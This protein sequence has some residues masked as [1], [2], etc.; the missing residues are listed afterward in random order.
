MV[1]TGERWSVSARASVQGLLE[2]NNKKKW[3]MLAHQRAGA[4]VVMPGVGGRNHRRAPTSGL[5]RRVSLLRLHHRRAP[6][7]G[8]QRRVSR[9]RLHHRRAPTSG[10]QR[11]VSRLR[12]RS[13]PGGGGAGG[14]IPGVGGRRSVPGGGGAGGVIPGVGG[15]RSVPGGGGVGGWC[16][17]VLG[18]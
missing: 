11:R 14:V 8:L 9:L 7:S 15:R 1:D 16:S 3:W 5:Q 10:L 17:A 13:V 4:G 2:L 18:P 12:L 6:T